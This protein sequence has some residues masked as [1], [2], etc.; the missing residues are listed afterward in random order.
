MSNSE[1]TGVLL[2]K[3][4]YSLR[5]SRGWSKRKVA[6]EL[7]VSIPS[8]MRW[9]DGSVIPNDYNINNIE[10][11]LERYGVVKKLPVIK[12]KQHIVKRMIA[13]GR[14]K[15]NTLIWLCVDALSD[16]LAMSENKE[17]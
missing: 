1:A 12:S 4:L 2:G 17:A 3:Q 13:L 9:E 5:M 6:I 7:G 16:Y 14:K 8:I 10:A 15:N 11:L